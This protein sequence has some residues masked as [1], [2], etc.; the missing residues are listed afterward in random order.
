MDRKWIKQVK[1]QAVLPKTQNDMQH[2]ENNI[3][4]N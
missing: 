2:N 1:F 3:F 4:F